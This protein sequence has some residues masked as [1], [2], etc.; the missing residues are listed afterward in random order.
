MGKH[1]T[2]SERAKQD[3]LLHLKGGKEDTFLWEHAVRVIGLAERIAKHPEV[4]NRP[5]NTLALTSAAYYHDMGWSLEY[6]RGA[7]QAWQVRSRATSDVQREKAAIWLEQRLADV[8]DKN[9]LTLAAETIRQCN[10][11]NAS[12][13]EAQILAEA[14][15]LD[16]IGPIVL[17]QQARQS[18]GDGR[19]IVAAIETWKRQDEYRFW[20]AKIK[21]GFRFNFTRRLARQRLK[22]MAKCFDALAGHVKGHDL[23]TIPPIEPQTQQSKSN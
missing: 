18:A 21:E 13:P 14:E 2:I 19:G 7:V 12:I 15:N 22:I 4:A 6:R 10:R 23:D 1:S 8:L 3:L 9:S 5:I 11:R 17:W 20:E 16:E